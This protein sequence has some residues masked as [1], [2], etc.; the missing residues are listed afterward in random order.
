METL[1]SSSKLSE[2]IKAFQ[3]AFS[4]SI[5]DKNT[6]EKQ[7]KTDRKMWKAERCGRIT[8]SNFGKILKCKK[9]VDSIILDVMGYQPEISSDAI[10]WGKINEKI[11]RDKFFSLKSSEHVNLCVR[12]T[13]LFIDIDEPYLAATPDGIVT[14]DCHEDYILE[15][16]CPFSQKNKKISEIEKKNFFLDENGT[17]KDTHNYYD[18]IQGQMAVAEIYKCYFVTYTEKELHCQIIDFDEYRWESSKEILQNFFFNFV[19]PEIIS[20]QMEKDIEAASKECL[21]K[22]KK[23]VTVVKCMKC[24]KTFHRACVNYRLKTAWLCDNCIL[25]K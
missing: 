17:L 9:S 25:V 21:C 7:S 22:I 13:G 3:V 16:K 10:L 24:K 20:C 23:I 18:Q 14:C 1:P 19:F 4:I 6:I 5:N 11:A 8:A 15:I 12:S 2:K